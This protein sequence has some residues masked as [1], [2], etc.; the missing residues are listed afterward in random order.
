MEPMHKVDVNFFWTPKGSG[1]V[2]EW[3]IISGIPYDVPGMTREA[4][5]LFDLRV[6]AKKFVSVDTQTG[7][8]TLQIPVVE[9]FADDSFKHPLKVSLVNDATEGVRIQLGNG[10][11]P[12]PSEDWEPQ[13]FLLVL[14]DGR[15]VQV[16]KK[17]NSLNGGDF[18]ISRFEFS[19][20]AKVAGGELHVVYKDG[21]R[22]AFDFA[23]DQWTYNNLLHL[24]TYVLPWFKK[25]ETKH[26]G[27]RL[28]KVQN[29]RDTLLEVTWFEYRNIHEGDRVY[30]WM[31]E[32]LKSIVVFPNAKNEKRTWSFT[33]K[34]ATSLR[35]TFEVDGLGASGK[36]CYTVIQDRSGRLQG[37]E[38]EQQH[39]V[40]ENGKSVTHT[41]MHR[42][43][44]E[45]TADGKV[46]RH[47]I[48]PGCGVD[49]MVHDYTYDGHVTRL[50]GYYRT[51]VPRTAFVRTYRFSA[52]QG[53]FEEYGSEAV[54]V[55]KQKSH[56]L[57]QGNKWLV[58]ETKEWEG[59]VVV[60]EQS[61]TLDSVG[62]PI[63]RSEKE[64]VTY[65]TYY[66]NY[67]EFRV[68][69]TAE[70]VQD[71]SFFGCLFKPIDYATVGAAALGGSGGLT[72]GT[73]IDTTVEAFSTSNGYARKAFNLPVEIKH[74]G[75]YRPLTSDVESE[76]VCRKLDGREVPERLTFFGYEHVA[77]QVLPKHKL[78]ILQ[79]D[80]SRVNVVKEQLAVATAA[81]EPFIN[82]LNKQIAASSGAEK[83]AFEQTLADLKKSL[84]AQSKVNG[85]GFKLNS[86]KAASMSLETFEYHANMSEAGYGT[87]KSLE[88]VLLD[89]DGKFIEASR[90]KTSFAYSEDANDAGRVVIKTTIS[91]KGETSVVSSQ[92]R[93]RNTGK[94]YENLD[95]EGIRTVYTYDP[96]G[97]LNSETVSKDGTV[98][99]TTTHTL[100][101]Q[102]VSQYDSV[103]DGTTTRVERDAL[104]RKQALWLKP[105]G[106]SSFIETQRWKYDALGRA[107][108]SVETDYGK[109][110]K[111]VSQRQTTWSYDESSGRITTTHVLKDAAGKDLK[112]VIQA[113]TP[114]VRGERFTQGTFS[115]DRQF[116]A[117]KGTLS[118]HYST[119]GSGGCKIERSVSGDG[120]VKALRYLKTDKAGKETEHDR[121]D[122]TYDD[123]AQLT[124]ATPR[125]GAATSYTYDRAGRLLTTTRDGGVLRN[126]YDASSL[127]PVAG[128]SHVESGSGKLSLGKQTIDM[129]GRASSQTV[130]GSKTEFS[131]VGAST[132]G[133]LKTPGSAPSALSDYD[134]SIDKKTRTHVQKLG[135]Q[136]STLVFSTGGRLLNFTDLT[137]A[138]T[139]YTYDFFNRVT[140]SSNDQCICIF[141]YA[142][143]GLLTSESI[144]AV[145]A[146]NLTMRVDYSY[147]ELGQEIKRTFTCEG[148]QTLSLER[149]LLA[150][151][152]LAKSSL[153]ASKADKGKVTESE[154][155]SDSYEYDKAS[156]LHKWTAEPLTTFPDD[157]RQIEWRYDALGNVTVKH[158]LRDPSVYFDYEFTERLV[159]IFETAA[160]GSTQPKSD[161]PLVPLTYDDSGRMTGDDGDGRLLANDKRRLSYHGNGQVKTYSVDGDKTRYS[162]SYDSE[163]RVRGGSVGKKTDTYHYRGDSV[164][165]LVQ[166]DDGKSDGFSK[167]TLVLR[168][169]SRGCLMQDAITDDKTSRSFEL[170][171]ANGTVFASVDLASKAI[172]FFRYE[173]YGKRFSGEKA[174]NW[175]GFKGEPLNRLGLY[176]LGNGYRLYDPGWGRFLTRDSRSP[177]G[178][179]GAAAY[180]FCNGD[181]VNNA[182]PSGH[183][184]IAQYSRWG[185][186]PAIQSLAFRVVVG[187]LSVLIAPF[188]AGTSMLLAIATTALAAISF[189]FDMAS[190]IIAESDPQLSRTLEAWGQVFGIIGSAVG[191]SMTLHD[192]KGIPK[193]M[194]KTRGG[195]SSG[196]SKPVKW[197]N[198]LSELQ[199]SNTG[200]AKALSR[201]VEEVDKAK[202]AGTYDVFRANHMPVEGGFSH[203]YMTALPL[204]ARFNQRAGHTAKNLFKGIIREVDDSLGDILGTIL[205][206][207]TGP[208]VLVHK[209]VPLNHSQTEIVSIAAGPLP[210][211]EH[212]FP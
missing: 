113:R 80:C 44:L 158:D 149:T 133:A 212:L 69:E 89:G 59:D 129:L 93:S 65:W 194:F 196:F 188:T 43:T 210:G 29:E 26:E 4:K 5:Q 9:L 205:D 77:F 177:F 101:G 164:Y 204:D 33:Q 51:A 150:D 152:R 183:Q 50:I 30:D 190:V 122:Y 157:F 141:S 78:V 153:K 83:K 14:R 92:T 2:V 117:E 12:L 25:I 208:A 84:D 140:S 136:S 108:S 187:A 20:E 116:N 82:S 169:E 31:P 104:G 10:N 134:G 180:V 191:I 107:A 192:I 131:Y 163:G 181:P 184:V 182:D 166:S 123:H 67:Q 42:E 34:T 126:T 165:A 154:V 115:V 76:L 46:D 17:M 23:M 142:D 95:T 61:I 90:R 57:D 32:M 145:K 143:N 185:T 130:N 94:L 121:I 3:Q 40:T 73:R 74:S 100:T 206:V 55:C 173:P 178:V 200:R 7:Q 146:G 88:T 19:H 106:A 174:E 56:R 68:T 161:S 102:L 193:N 53:F 35:T 15:G 189:A 160:G 103:E 27:G 91:R 49:D 202:A 147:D 211:Q 62:S 47:T 45:Y 21:L 137:K 54:P 81:A 72:W 36:T 71:N 155:Y 96:Q 124:K 144:K 170:R 60:D 48:S 13:K 75:S 105:S 111:Q 16:D 139:T 186:A 151:G 79:P 52:G 167:R 38:I 1:L 201:L 22:E 171:D 6:E 70:K 112:K 86:W 197:P 99:R 135:G 63:S 39:A 28:Y 120:L 195:P 162:F 198:T 128:E 64:R 98:L 18:K 125:L 127:A 85:E 37:I 11:Q 138:T 66:N 199:M 24:N 159:Q 175:L 179:G 207:H 203:G 172:T 209:Y 110:N 114:S 148:V 118:E 109:D 8:A 168:N 87:V 41:S 156:R 132:K 119:S 176:H 58:S 97:N